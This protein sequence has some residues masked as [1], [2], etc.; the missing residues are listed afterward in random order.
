MTVKRAVVTG[1]GTG[2]GRATSALLLQ[3]GFE[4]VAV[5]RSGEPLEQ[6]VREMGEPGRGITPLRLDVRDGAA[7]QQAL[8]SDYDS[9][10]AA[11]GG[12]HDALAGCE[13]A[14]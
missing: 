11:A 4:V 8:A 5:G 3:R 1:A 2:I 7:L 13:R 12:D 9:V 14:A 6:L 10:V